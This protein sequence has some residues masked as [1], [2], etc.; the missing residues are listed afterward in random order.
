MRRCAR[1]S[2]IVASCKSAQCSARQHKE[3]VMRARGAA[4]RVSGVAQR[5]VQEMR[6][7]K[8]RQRERIGGEEQCRTPEMTEPR[9][10]REVREAG[11]FMSALKQLRFRCCL[12]CRYP[13]KGLWL[14]IIILPSSLPA[15]TLHCCHMPRA[16]CSPFPGHRHH[17]REGCLRHIMIVFCCL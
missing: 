16:H 9:F 11:V 13:E 8:E 3:A 5:A 17:H 6:R 7:R 1:A 4:A 2:A 15:V 14:S 12:C 10:E